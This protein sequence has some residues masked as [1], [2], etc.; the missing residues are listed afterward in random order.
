M[1]PIA[2][3]IVCVA[4][5]S[6]ANA[7]E[8][9]AET[10][11]RLHSDGKGWKLNQATIKDSQQP[12]VLLLG[13]S[14]LSGYMSHAIHGP[15][16]NNWPL[17]FSFLRHTFA[18]RVPADADARRGPIKLNTLAGEAGHLGQNW[19]SAR[20]GYQLLD[21]ARLPRFAASAR[22]HPGSSTPTTPPTGKLFNAMAESN[23]IVKLDHERLA[24]RVARDVSCSVEGRTP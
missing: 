1:K 17:V 15:G 3:W 10:D 8:P 5:V 21:T 7:A 6:L 16:E 22:P 14:I 9:P 11:P 18:A 24:R 2:P 20:G 12:R 19:D 23:R 4:L 13:D